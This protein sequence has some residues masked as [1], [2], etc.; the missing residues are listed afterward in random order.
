MHLQIFISFTPA[1]RLAGLVQIKLANCTGDP[2]D[3]VFADTS[4]DVYIYP[5][6]IYALYYMLAHES[7]ILVNLRVSDRLRWG[8]VGVV[9]SALMVLGFSLGHME[10]D[11]YD[12]TSTLPL[13]FLVG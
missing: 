7:R 1:R 6:V 10:C 8:E 9:I 2:R 3:M 4:W 13:C 11:C 5:L 12:S